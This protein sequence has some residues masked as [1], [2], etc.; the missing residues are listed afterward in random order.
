[1]TGLLLALALVGQPE[2]INAARQYALS[3]DHVK[4]NEILE[5]LAPDAKTYNEYHYYRAVNHFKL[6]EKDKVATHLKAIDD[7]FDPLPVRHKA[8]LSMMAADLKN[9]EDGDLN[10]I[11]RDMTVSK[12]RL[13]QFKA[14]GRTAKSQKDVIDKLD[15]LIKKQEDDAAKAA[16]AAAAKAG[17]MPMPGML[18]GDGSPLPTLPAPD[19]KVMGGAGPGKVDD[20]K[21]REVAEQWGTLPPDRR[22][23]LVH[24]LTRDLPPR[25]KP[26]IDEYFRSLNRLHPQR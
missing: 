21:L 1:M 18:P 4:S 12:D 7:S 24:E 20:R 16:A 6:N 5:K 17:G 11:S 26:M 25:Y 15:K 10:D 13:D 8:V 2:D 19:S 14:G 23:A 9:W 22:A 3:G